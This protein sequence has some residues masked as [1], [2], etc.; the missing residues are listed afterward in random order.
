MR[1]GTT[2]SG[3]MN[4][5]PSSRLGWTGTTCGSERVC[6]ACPHVHVGYGLT[7]F[8]ARQFTMMTQSTVFSTPPRRKDHDMGGFP[9]PIELFQRLTHTNAFGFIRRTWDKVVIK[10]RIHKERSYLSWIPGSID[11]LVIGQNSEF[12]TD[13][14]TDEQLEHLG[15]IEY[16]ALRFLSYLV[17][18]VRGDRCLASAPADQFHPSST[19]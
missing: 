5:H 3:G 8:L 7:I 1:M 9:G 10:W 12:C 6:L 14:L 11:E 15:G 4:D 13:E 18:T 16:R 19:S 17:F 2:A